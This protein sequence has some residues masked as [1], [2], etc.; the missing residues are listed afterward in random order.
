MGPCLCLVFARGLLLT[1]RDYCTLGCRA[2]A[3]IL[4]DIQ[5]VG[6]STRIEH[7]RGTMESEMEARF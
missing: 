4:A 1:G 2:C 3:G 5:G 7:E 6:R